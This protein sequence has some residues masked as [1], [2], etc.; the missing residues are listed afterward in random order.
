MKNLFLILVLA[1]GFSP[2]SAFDLVSTEEVM[3]IKDIPT[4]NIMANDVKKVV[5]Y[6]YSTVSNKYKI[7]SGE[8]IMRGVENDSKGS[9]YN[10]II[11]RFPEKNM[12]IK[13]FQYFNVHNNILIA[14]GE[15]KG[16]INEPEYTV[17]ITKST[18]INNKKNTGGYVK[19]KSTRYISAL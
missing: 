16:D 2:A 12:D 19:N 14:I 9:G 18:Q 13:I 10:F 15:L 1:L 3:A 6:K 7:W 4:K 17:F 11:V 8:V 5:I